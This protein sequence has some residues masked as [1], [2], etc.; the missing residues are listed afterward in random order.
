MGRVSG[1]VA[2]V[3]GAAR[4]MG[5]AFARRLIE[6]GAQVMLTDVLDEEGRA[7][8][9]ALGG[10]ARFAHHDVTRETEWKRI[11]SE[12]ETA[13][14]PVSVLVNNAGIGSMAPSDTLE[15]S[16]YRQVIDVNQI[17]VFLGMKSVL[18]SMKRAGGGAMINI[19]SV[20]G[21]VGSP[22]SLAY[23]A[24]K[25]A[26]RGMTKAAAIEFAPHQIRVN[27]VHPGFVKTPMSANMESNKGMLEH[28]LAITPVHRL[29]H[30]DEVASVVLLLASDE[31]RFTTGAD[32]VVDGGFTCQ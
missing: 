4:G 5:A 20:L 8:A 27:A 30:P 25:F 24:S 29:G 10:N 12:T 18:P 15:E 21:M 1:K 22:M 28:V 7:T 26:V 17:S 2:I 11:V 16:A 14:G 6:E 31:S 9:Q 13:F 19:A 32:F 3:T 23:V